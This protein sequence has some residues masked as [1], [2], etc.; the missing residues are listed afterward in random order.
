MEISVSD[1]ILVGFYRYS[2]RVLDAWVLRCVEKGRL[3][4]ESNETIARS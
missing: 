1:L 4:F 3:S 2:D